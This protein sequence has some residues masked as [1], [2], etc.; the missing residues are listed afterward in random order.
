MTFLLSA[1]LCVFP[2]LHARLYHARGILPGIGVP[3][4]KGV[5]L[6]TTQYRRIANGST[7]CRVYIY[8]AFEK[9]TQANTINHSS[10][11]D[12]NLLRKHSRALERN[13]LSLKRN[14]YGKA[15]LHNRKAKSTKLARCEQ[16]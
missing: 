3:S 12:G 16:S 5:Q 15:K 10:K 13:A 7:A 1:Y 2:T 14:H 8:L 9:N 4:G 6:C 11:G